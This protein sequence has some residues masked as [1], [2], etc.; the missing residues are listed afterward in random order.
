MGDIWCAGEGEYFDEGQ[1]D[2]EGGLVIHKGRGHTTTGDP[3]SFPDRSGPM[4]ETPP[5]EG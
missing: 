1:F 5:D 2:N 3:V 4:G